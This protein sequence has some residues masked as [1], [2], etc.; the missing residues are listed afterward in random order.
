[1]EE[2]KKAKRNIVYIKAAGIAFDFGFIIVIP[3]L[4]SVFFGKKLDVWIGTK[5]ATPIAIALAMIVSAYFVWREI[6][7]I[8]KEMREI[9][10]DD[11]A[12]PE[13]TVHSVKQQDEPHPL[14]IKD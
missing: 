13:V 2:D 4:V 8:R 5:L 3:L 6:K 1:M 9:S 14:D 12:K 7:E 11:V 10:N